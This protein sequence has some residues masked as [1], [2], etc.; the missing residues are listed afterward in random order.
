MKFSE[1]DAERVKSKYSNRSFAH[2]HLQNFPR[3]DHMNSAGCG[4]LSGRFSP[5]LPIGKKEKP[6]L[7]HFCYDRIVGSD[8]QAIN[9]CS[10]TN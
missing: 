6:E 4:K 8:N 1:S 9:L 7:H 5:R 10:I 2:K 3:F